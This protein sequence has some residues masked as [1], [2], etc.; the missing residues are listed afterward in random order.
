MKV[1]FRRWRR[2]AGI[3]AIFPAEAGDMVGLTCKA[4][5]GV[6]H[7]VIHR[8]YF[9]LTQVTRPVTEA[10]DY[11]SLLA[12]LETLGVRDIEVVARATVT[13][14]VNRQHEAPLGF[15]KH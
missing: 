7:Q 1:I 10:N 8:D 4:Y 3:V 2:N 12:E 13:D 11:Q 6:T 9:A 15:V 14:L 5:D